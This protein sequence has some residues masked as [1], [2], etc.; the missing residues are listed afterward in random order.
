MTFIVKPAS[1]TFAILE[2]RLPNPGNTGPNEQ[3]MSME[4]NRIVAVAC[5]C[6]IAVGGFAQTKEKKTGAETAQTSAATTASQEDPVL[7]TVD[8]KPVTRGE[9]EAIYKKNN[10]DV[11]V[12][13]EAL[14]EYLELF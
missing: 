3:V 8:G 7:M 12:T 13:K 11:Q 5:L 10:K 6:V 1:V 2:N 9:F 4:F 14:D